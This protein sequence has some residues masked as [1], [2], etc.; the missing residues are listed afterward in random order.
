MAFLLGCKA[1]YPALDTVEKV[2]L[3][4][5]AGKWYEI[6]T[7]PQGFQEGCVCSMAEYKVNPKGYVEVK[8]SCR[9]NTPGGKLKT[10]KG[11]AFPVKGTGN[12]KLKVQFFWPFRADY[13]IVELA[14]DYSYAAVGNKSRKYLWILSRAPSLPDTTYQMLLDKL[15]KKQFDISMLEKTRQ[16]CE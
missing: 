5:Y 2:D 1:Q 12:S 8:N 16:D 3:E 14:P 15:E 6:A 13:W 11:K 10:V 7:I 9:K 4:K